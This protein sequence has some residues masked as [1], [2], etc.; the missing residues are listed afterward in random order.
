MTHANTMSPRLR[1]HLF[2]SAT[3]AA[4][5]A[6]L[7]AA[8]ARADPTRASGASILVSDQANRGESIASGTG[9]TQVGATVGGALVATTV[10]LSAN[11]ISAAARGN[12]VV[13]DLSVSAFDPS[14][15]AGTI[16]VPATDTVDAGNGA[17][18]VSR[19]QDVGT[20]VMAD[21]RGAALTLASGAVEQSHV[22]VARNQLSAL[23]LGNDAQDSLAASGA[24]AANG[25][26]LVSMQTIDGASAVS[27]ESS[28]STASTSS[29]IAAS[30]ISVTGNLERA[31]GYANR[32]V[33]ALSVT[34]NQ[35]VPLPGASTAANVASPAGGDPQAS[36]AFL[37]LSS[38]ASA[39]P[40]VARVESGVG[41]PA[42][43]V[44]A[45]AVS[46]GSSIASDGNSRIAAGYGNVSGNGLDLQAGSISPRTDS[47][48][49]GAI[50]GVTGVQRLTG[51]AGVTASVAGMVGSAI[52]GDIASASIATTNNSNAAIATG[53]LAS[54][55]RLSVSANSIVAD[56]GAA[57]SALTSPDGAALAS[58]TFN[59]ENVQSVDRNRIAATL[60]P[61]DFAVIGNGD[62]SGSVL[63]SS[64]NT[65][66]AA[67]TANSAV[68]AAS[69]SAIDVNGGVAVNS[70]QSA[71][72]DVASTINA[73][74]HPGGA[75]IVAQGMTTA[76]TL[77]VGGNSLAGSA[78]GN[79]AV[80]SLSVSAGSVSDAAGPA[81]SQAGS[82]A[83]G[84]GAAATFALAN[85]QKLGAPAGADAAVSAISSTI[86]GRYSVNGD[87]GTDRST[88]AL[89]G[90][91]QQATALGND[92][93][94]QLAV[95][96][97]TTADTAS[98]AGA[99]LSSSQF[100]NANL[101]ALSDLKVASKGAATQS[102]IAMSRNTNAARATIN[103]A[104]NE[105]A[106]T[107]TGSVGGY[108]ALSSD[109]LG[110]PLAAGDNVIANQQFAAGSAT[111]VARTRVGSGDAGGGLAASTLDVTGTDTRGEASANA[112]LNIL[113][114]GGGAAG[115]TGGAGL[116][117]VQASTARV[118]ARATNAVLFAL[119]G[120]EGHPA[121]N[122]SSVTIADNS[123]AAL[124]RGNVADNSIAVTRGNDA[125]PA[126][127][128]VSSDRFGTALNASEALLN[129]QT[130]IGPV[131]ATASNATVGV[132]LNGPGAPLTASMIGETGNAI[133]ATGY[134]NIATNNIQGTTP[135]G[136]F[137]PAISSV[138]VNE[139]AVSAQATG[140]NIA[141][142]T[143]GM[144]STMLSI[145]GNQI[146]ASATGNQANN[147]ITLKR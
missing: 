36:A 106:A 130:N 37:T 60:V 118:D 116:A 16:A 77:T 139:A 113:T 136:S 68:N 61:G 109:P 137:V 142:R 29:D 4:L 26:A 56:P 115:A 9:G 75:L 79:R 102:S 27:A 89:D 84:Y 14:A 124:A 6:T 19:Q 131:T 33:S 31:V 117:N 88:I 135:G 71:D 55:N 21:G 57:A 101:T 53:N 40:V 87:G 147:V 123:S 12:Q 78:T 145:T 119:T 48:A 134:G 83:G 50:A 144:T 22:G 47:A 67:A 114:I 42:F 51:S 98:H 17:L 81:P 59:V 32:G 125:A 129:N 128:T 65:A 64:G 23:A 121:L 63:T 111:A 38:Q 92:T 44:V 140:A 73:P 30:D 90:N 74:G 52:D 141:A 133:M 11:L 85:Q 76:S 46:A 35:I 25:A 70:L 104:D 82:L 110:P 93:V 10:D 20:T 107:G 69:I 86:V 112:A 138:Q 18:L 34:A 105:L 45:Q 43:G 3:G 146:V 143:D 1:R 108:A 80:N 2:R 28:A 99:A 91:G 24:G 54:G 120:S 39:A 66:L 127:A 49:P 58:G 100:G 94:N 103:Q 62:V 13:Q 122:G 15:D 126:P 97:T 95:G 132:A 41:L 5:V 96:A 7:A 72:G 8:P